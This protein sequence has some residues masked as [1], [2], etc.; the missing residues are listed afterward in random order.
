MV[1]RLSLMIL[2]DLIIDLDP[3]H[4]EGGVEIEIKHITLDSRTAGLGSLFFAVRGV[5]VD[6]HNFINEVITHGAVAIICEDIPENTYEGVTYIK[7]SKVNDCIG[8][9]ASAF[10]GHPSLELTIVGVTGTNGKTTIATTLYDLFT[11][12]GEKSGLISTVEN[13]IG[14]EIIPATHTTPDAVS[15]QE[16]LRKMSDADCKYVFMEVSSHAVDQGRIKNIYFL[17]GIFTNLTQDHLDYHKTMDSY[18]DAK[19]AFFDSLPETA[20]ALA[21]IDDP[22]GEFMIRDSRAAHVTYAEGK[23]DF[24][25]TIEESTSLGMSLSIKDTRVTS[26]LVGKFNA[27]N[28][29]AIFATAILLDQPKDTVASTLSLLTGARGRMEKITGMS[30]KVG[31]IDYAHTPDALENAL[32]TVNN[33]KG[34]SKVITVFG[35]GGDRDKTKRPLMGAVASKLSD[36][37]IVTSDNPRSEDPEQIIK[38]I[39][40]GVSNNGGQI[41]SVGDREEAIKMAVEMAMPGDIV[42]VAGK[43]HEDYQDVKGVKTHFSDKEVLKKYL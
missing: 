2:K 3:L 41:L 13:K 34:E 28:L 18:A 31:I 20:F 43:G 12:L 4:I 26:P 37:I 14:G 10:Y 33:F 35:A 22:Y 6:G 1:S 38:D 11:K 7:V 5:K 32:T 39:M 36:A 8:V 15:L 25:F 17:G 19:K 24:G 30:G 42:F 40:S 23:G 9:I 27:Y 21:N 16:Y 29:A